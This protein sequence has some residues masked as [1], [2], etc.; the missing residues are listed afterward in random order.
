MGVAKSGEEA[1]RSPAQPKFNVYVKF[2]MYT[3]KIASRRV[4]TAVIRPELPKNSQKM[5]DFRHKNGC[6]PMNTS[7]RSY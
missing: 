5:A 1:R 3:L 7:V 4:S 2:L 6:R